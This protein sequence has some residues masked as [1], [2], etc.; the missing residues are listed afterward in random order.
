MILEDARLA[1]A[2]AKRMLATVRDGAADLGELREALE[3]SQVFMAAG[4]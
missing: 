1:T 2:A 4:M 3:Q